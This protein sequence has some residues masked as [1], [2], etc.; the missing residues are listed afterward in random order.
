MNGNCPTLLRQI[1]ELSFT[2]LELAL[3]LDTHPGCQD[4]LSDFRRVNEK[5]RPIMDEY[6]RACAPLV[7]SE[8]GMNTGRWN[9]IDEPWPW[10]MNY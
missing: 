8:A 4:A 2:S 7:L 3:F 9:W 10:E 5:L 6:Q 1:M